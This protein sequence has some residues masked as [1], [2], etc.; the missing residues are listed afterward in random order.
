MT[1]VEIFKILSDTNRLRILNLLYE[2]ELCVCELEYLLGVSQSNL[3]KHLRLMSDVGFLESRRENKFVY[4]RIKDE[5]LEEHAFLKSI[6]EIELKKEDYLIEELD[7][8]N[9]YKKS[10]ITCQN[11]TALICEKVIS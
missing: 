8:L 11:I 1:A 4:Y 3:S 5:V 10:A 6:F 7:K 9:S 2:K